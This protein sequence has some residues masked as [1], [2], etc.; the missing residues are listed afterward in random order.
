MGYRN[1]FWLLEYHWWHLSKQLCLDRK[2]LEPVLKGDVPKIDVP[3]RGPGGYLRFR[4]NPKYQFVAYI[5]VPVIS[6]YTSPFVL[7][8]STSPFFDY[9]NYIP[10]VVFFVD[11]HIFVSNLADIPIR[12]SKVVTNILRLASWRWPSGDFL[13]KLENDPENHPWF[14]LVYHLCHGFHSITVM[15]K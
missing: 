7:V 4:D 5:L 6:W 11:P 15:G 3:L 1:I 12:F 8:T 9:A 2:F 14:I 13:A 10:R